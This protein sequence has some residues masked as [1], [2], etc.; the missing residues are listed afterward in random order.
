MDRHLGDGARITRRKIL[1]GAAAIGAG[2]GFIGPWRWARAQSKKAMA[3]VRTRCPGM[4]VE[5][6]GDAKRGRRAFVQA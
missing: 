4:V 2:V 6:T 1:K 5:H 3:S